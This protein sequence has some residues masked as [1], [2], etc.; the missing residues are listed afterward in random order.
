MFR[1]IVATALTGWAAIV[2]IAWQS[3]DR[4]IENC[5]LAGVTDSDCVIRLSAQRDFIL[6][7]GLAVALAFVVAAMIVFA[8][9]QA[10]KNRGAATGWTPTSRAQRQLPR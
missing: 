5:T 1:I 2:G 10:R 6:T 4:R 8:V 7:V 9:N 3:A